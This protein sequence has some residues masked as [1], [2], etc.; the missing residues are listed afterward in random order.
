MRHKHLLLLSM[1]LAA[2][3]AYGF[4]TGDYTDGGIEYNYD[5]SGTTI[6]A[7]QPTNLTVTS[8][9]IP[10]EVTLTDRDNVTQTFTV[11]A[12]GP[13]FLRE[14][15]SGTPNL[16]TLGIPS[17]ITE[18]RFAYVSSSV[19]H[20]PKFKVDADN[21]NFSSGDDGRQTSSA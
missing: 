5:G 6:T 10:K 4:R 12:I 15:D 14:G 18:F 13:Y 20:F 8:I 17:T 3:N 1:L 16:E 21:A 7:W 9:D 19:V 2:A 11:T